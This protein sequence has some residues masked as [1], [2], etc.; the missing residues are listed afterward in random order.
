M[1]KKIEIRNYRNHVK[2][3]VIFSPN[4]TSIIGSSYAGKSTIIRA[5]RWVMTNKPAGDQFINW[6]AE[7]TIVRVTFDNNIKIIRKKGKGINL[8]K[9]NKKEF[10]AFGNNVPSE[11]SDLFNIAEIN[12]Q[13]QH[14]APFWFCETAGEVSRQLN[15][16]V[17]L[18][19]IDKSLANIASKIRKTNA[20]IEIGEDRLT[21]L[22][23][24]HDIKTFIDHKDNDLK[25]IEFL[26]N[27]L[28]KKR[29]ERSEMALLVNSIGNH[30]RTIEKAQ[31]KA[32]DA[33]SAVSAG[34]KY[35]KIRKDRIQLNN[36]INGINNQAAIAD[37][38]PPPFSAI[39]KKR[40]TL[41][42]IFDECEAI[43]ELLTKI[44]KVTKAE[45]DAWDKFDR[46]KK[47]MKKLIGDKCPLCQRPMK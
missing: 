28:F 46:L 15:G 5:L 44:K 43:A 34:D 35:C 27:D 11:I 41:E 30:A 16:I 26:N 3:D 14:D 4:V 22:I 18:E 2:Q 8:Y 12:F 40:K 21:K 39:I 33:L 31:N 7:R 20:A 25:K 45:Q 37:N 10:K 47:Q 32:S 19:V 42:K 13:G 29:S 9:L 1:I 23:E 6:D 24:E 17:N 38:A 36:L